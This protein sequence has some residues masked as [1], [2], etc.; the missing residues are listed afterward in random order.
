MLMNLA[1]W[2]ISVSSPGFTW[3]SFWSSMTQDLTMHSVGTIYRPQSSY[4]EPHLCSIA[5]HKK[6]GISWTSIRHAKCLHIHLSQRLISHW[7][8]CQSLQA[9]TLG[10]KMTNL[11]LEC[12][13]ACQYTH[14][15]STNCQHVITSDLHPNWT[16]DKNFSVR[17]GLEERIICLTTWQVSWSTRPHLHLY[18]A[19]RGLV[20]Q[21]L[22]GGSAQLQYYSQNFAGGWIGLENIAS[23]GLYRCRA[24]RRWSLWHCGHLY[25]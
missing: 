24:S 23:T 25:I 15:C 21:L 17:T 19:S 2:L 11:V 14:S 7:L 5:S 3:I 9:I 18:V 20:V 12:R 16:F 22:A 13:E 10:I 1:I 4:V 6:D 8:I